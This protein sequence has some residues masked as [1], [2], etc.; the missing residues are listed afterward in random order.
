MLYE[1]ILKNNQILT[2][3]YSNE[4]LENFNEKC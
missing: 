3:Y 4:I 2:T 1:L